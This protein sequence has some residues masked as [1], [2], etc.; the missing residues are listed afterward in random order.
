MILLL[1]LNHITNNHTHNNNDNNINN[2]NN[3]NNDN[4]VD[5]TVMHFDRL[6]IRYATLTDVNIF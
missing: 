3:S 5:A 2:N 4:G 6:G 1:L